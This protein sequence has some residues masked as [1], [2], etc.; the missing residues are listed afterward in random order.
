MAILVAG[1]SNRVTLKAGNILV[2]TGVGQVGISPGIFDGVSGV[3]YFGPYDTARSININATSQI[4][5]WE[6]ENDNS[7]GETNASPRDIYAFPY[8]TAGVQAA[9]DS[10]ADAGA[11]G[12]VNL[13]AVD[14]D[15][16]AGPVT[17]RPGAS[18]KGALPLITPTGGDV[19][20]SVFFV[21]GGTRII[22]APGQYSFIFNA[23]P[24]ASLPASDLAL[25]G[26][27]GLSFKRMASIGGAGLLSAGSVNTLGLQKCQ[28]D[29][30][31]WQDASDWGIQLHNYMQLTIGNIT[32]RQ[33]VKGGG[34]RYSCTLGTRS[35]SAVLLPGNTVWNG[36]TH[37]FCTHMG[38]RGIEI[39]NK[40]TTSANQHNELTN[41]G[42]WQVNRFAGGAVDM[43]LA[44]TNGSPDIVIANA[45]HYDL[46]IESGCF[47]FTSTAPTGFNTIDTY[48]VVNKND[49]NQTIQLATSNYAFTTTGISAGSTGS[50]TVK[51][52]GTPGLSINN[53]SLSL[54]T[55]ADLG[56]LDLEL[57]GNICTI[58]ARRCRSTNGQIGE[59]RASEH[60]G[61]ITLRDAHLELKC[62]S[63]AGLI[64]NS[65]DSNSRL[66][67]NAAE[68]DRAVNAAVPLTVS[69]HSQ[70]LFVN[71]AA[72]QDFTVDVNMPNDFRVKLV[73]IGAGA[74]GF[75]AGAGVT[76]SSTN[77][78]TAA[79][80][81][82]IELCKV[83]NQ[84]NIYYVIGQT[85]P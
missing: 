72:T 4:M 1:S 15:F 52:G 68:F 56:F 6:E 64:R 85:G 67:L 39:Y 34:I 58:W 21:T 51:Y 63:L 46:M 45:A 22:N 16:S 29:D 8:T 3:G 48:F 78:R 41:K 18:I 11:V 19:P 14:F 32:A 40:T 24:Q 27:Y 61:S 77:K 42:R 50:H 28:L 10:I 9:I 23:T 13:A 31:F 35:V 26:L 62:N 66:R 53:D 30:L 69:E 36:I 2:V 75:V 43:S 71:N 17:L 79:V 47:G 20:D 82:E 83:P 65:T 25:T 73:Q 49:A 84:Q 7:Q 74:A 38:S 80:G 54:L 55:V 60:F 57:E 37:I 5:Y 81:A 59:I 12:T 76:I 70:R 33:S 44:F